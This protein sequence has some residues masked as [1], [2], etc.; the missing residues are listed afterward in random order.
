MENDLNVN[1]NV[2]QNT[3]QNATQN[4]AQNTMKDTIQN[5]AQNMTQNATQNTTQSISQNTAQEANSTPEPAPIVAPA[6]NPAMI[7]P[8]PE[9][10]V[11]PNA[12]KPGSAKPSSEKSPIEEELEKNAKPKKEKKEKRIGVVQT[13]LI[14]AAVGLLFSIIGTMAVIFVQ[15]KTTLFDRFLTSDA[16]EEVVDTDVDVVDTDVEP[17]PATADPTTPDPAQNVDPISG[18]SNN[19]FS[20]AYTTVITGESDVITVTE[21]A[22]PSMVTIIKEFNYVDSS[23]AQYFG[24]YGQSFVTQAS[25]SG[26]IIAETDTEYLIVSNNHVVEN[27]ISLEITFADGTSA[28]GYIKGCDKG[29]DV[30]VVAVLKDDISDETVDAIRIASLGDSNNLRLGEQ[31][32]AIGNALGYG[33]SVTTGIISAL[34]REMETEEGYVNKFIQTDAAINPGNS[35]GALLNMAGQVIGINSNKLAETD[36]EGMGYA[37]PISD[38]TDIIEELMEHSTKIP[39]PDDEV[40]YIGISLQEVTASLASR[41][42]MPVGIYIVETV[43]GGAAEAAG[44]L[45]GDVITE[46]AGEKVES[47]DDLDR[48]LQCY[49][50]GETVPITYQR[51]ENGE[52]V[53]YKTNLTLGAKP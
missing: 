39:L 51:S 20:T 21:N 52:Y 40:G 37:I 23:Y 8:M 36:V 7:N 46:F 11:V 44:L 3:M 48:I 29:R 53:E 24:S 27:P 1:E 31:V 41:F 15:N 43:D 33:Q 18:S 12:A 22:M 16:P 47:Y 14:S 6:I 5:E 34:N 9:K 19:S 30:A 4:A 2:A 17:D 25:G 49:A 13:I 32:V 26:F 10:V 50:A 35:G 45:P 42:G 28:A 38:V